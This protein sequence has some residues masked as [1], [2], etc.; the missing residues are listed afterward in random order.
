[1]RIE[2]NCAVCGRNSFSLDDASENDSMVVCRDCGHEIGTI[3]QL[4]DRIADEV[5]ARCRPRG[6]AGPSGES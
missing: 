3:Q 2:L 6:E 4:K 1:M 5:M